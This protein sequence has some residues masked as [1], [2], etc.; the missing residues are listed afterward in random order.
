VQQRRCCRRRHTE[1]SSSFVR[2]GLAEQVEQQ[3]LGVG[4][5]Q[6]TIRGLVGPGHGQGGA[7]VRAIPQEIAN[8]AFVEL[9]QAL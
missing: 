2:R 5:H 8:M 7:V 4:R 1:R 9:C 6:G 3:L